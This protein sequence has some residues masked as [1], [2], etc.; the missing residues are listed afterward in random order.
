MEGL[1]PSV[2]FYQFMGLDGSSRTPALLTP[3]RLVCDSNGRPI[4]HLDLAAADR[5]APQSIHRPGERAGQSAE[6]DRRRSSNSSQ[7]PS[8]EGPG[9]KPPERRQ[10]SD[11]KRGGQPGPPGA[12]PELQP[13]VRVDEVV[14]HHSEACRRCAIR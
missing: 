3:C 9:F 11:C 10:G 7:P 4:L 6:A 1:S 14:E 12:G 13:I 2:K 5:A 8:S